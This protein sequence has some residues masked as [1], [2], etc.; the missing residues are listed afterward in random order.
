MGKSLYL[1]L[2]LS[3]ERLKWVSGFCLANIKLQLR[4]DFS[5]EPS[6]CERE[7]DGERGTER[8]CEKAQ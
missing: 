2:S 4:T 1:S 8:K 6:V 5:R 7:R 3:P